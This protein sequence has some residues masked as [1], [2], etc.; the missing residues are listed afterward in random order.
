[1]TPRQ[2]QIRFFAENAGY[3]TPPGR[4]ACAKALADAENFASAHDWEVSWEWDEGGDLGDHDYWC[5][6]EDCSHEIECAIL[7]DPH[8][9][10]LASLGSIIDADRAYRRVVAA[11]LASE[12]MHVEQ[13]ASLDM[14][15]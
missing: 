12:A 14:V 10:V 9:N 4:M 2:Q 13:E 6:R 5:G 11:E 15:L 3:A 1:M 7:R 8:G